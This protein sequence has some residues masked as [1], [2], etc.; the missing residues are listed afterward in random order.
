[1]KR[2]IKSFNSKHFSLGVLILFTSLSLFSGLNKYIFEPNEIDSRINSN[3]FVRENRFEFIAPCDAEVE[4]LMTYCNSFRGPLNQASNIIQD[5]FFVGFRIIDKTGGT[6]NVIDRLGNN[7][8][9]RGKRINNITTEE[10]VFAALGLKCMRRFI[11][12]RSY[13]D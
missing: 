1:M 5:S 13:I 12:H 11:L 8:T 3:Q 9:N 10:E 2:P 6:Y 7:V 4:G